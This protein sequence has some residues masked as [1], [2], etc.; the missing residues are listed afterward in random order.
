MLNLP[1]ESSTSLITQQGETALK[2]YIEM[3][4]LARHAIHMSETLEVG[5]RTVKEF[6][7]SCKSWHE[8]SEDNSPIE[9][10]TGTITDNLRFS[11]DFLSNLKK[12][13]DA[14]TDRLDNEIRLVSTQ[15]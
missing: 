14:F 5:S 15:F 6:L 9:T 2:K 11:S 4:E 10:I 3:H 13:A 1:A 12:R 7:Q 8:S